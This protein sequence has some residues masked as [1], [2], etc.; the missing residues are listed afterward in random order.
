MFLGV[1]G[2]PVSWFGLG[3]GGLFLLVLI[4]RFRFCF[5]IVDDLEGVELGQT[6]VVN[7]TELEELFKKSDLGFVQIVEIGPLDDP[8]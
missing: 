3:F 1:G 5:E 6:F 8:S 4:I 7:D 2:V